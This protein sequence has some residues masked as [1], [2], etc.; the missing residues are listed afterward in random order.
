MEKKIIIFFWLISVFAIK[1]FPERIILESYAKYLDSISIA[2]IPFTTNEEQKI[3]KNLPWEILAS[4]LDFSGKVSVYK[5]SSL[6]TSFFIKNNIPIYI[7]GFYEIFGNKFIRVEFYVKDSHTQE[8]L[9]ER[10]YEGELS[11]TRTMAHKFANVLIETLFGDKGIFESR[12]IFVKDEGREKNIMIMDWDGENISHLTNTKVMN[13]FPVF[14]DSSNFLWVSYMRGQPDIYKGTIGGKAFNFISSRFIETSPA[15]CSITGKI[16]FAS[17]RD[18][19]ME[20]YTCN[21]DGNNIKRITNSWA[22][23]ISPCWAPNGYQIAFTSDRTGSP[24]IFVMNADGS[25][26]HQLT[27][28][29]N[30]QDSPSWSPKGDKIA[31]HSLSEGKFDIW[32]CDAD[33]KNAQRVTNLPGNNEYPSWALDGIHIVFSNNIGGKSNL[34]ATTL[35]G[36]KIKKLTDSGNAKMPDWGQ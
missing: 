26:V 21:S 3:T 35:D 5:I 4:D 24:K 31:F 25:N 8:N 36:R 18:G 20:I 17:S 16:V 15:Y 27:F 28:E 32:V 34:Y 2:I 12:I 7:D 19:N 6:D 23:D 13:I 30:Y 33:G 14:M 22:I 9:L 10:K 1:S 11:Q 29:T